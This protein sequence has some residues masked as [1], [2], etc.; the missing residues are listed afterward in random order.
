MVKT[1][2]TILVICI[3]IFSCCEVINAADGESDSENDVPDKVTLNADRVSFNDETG[4]ALAEGRAVMT[5]NDTTIMAERIEY[6]AASQK[7]QAMPLPGEKIILKQE[8]RVLRGDQLNYNLNTK[9][10]ILSGAATKIGIGENNATLYVHGQDI[11]VIP[12]SVA[13]ERGLVRGTPEDYFVRWHNVTFTTCE[14]DHPHYRLES[15][16]ITFI[17]GKRIIARRPRVYLGNTYLFTSPFD[18][19]LRLQRKA[20]GYSFLPYLQ[21]SDRKGS[22]GGMSGALGWDTGSVSLGGSWSRKAKFEYKIDIDQEIND[23]FSINIGVEHTWNDLWREKFYHPYASLIYD[24]NGWNARL[25]WSRN[26][27]ISERKDAITE[28]KGKVTREPEFIIYAPWF[29]SSLYSWMRVF[30]SYG[31]YKESLYMLPQDRS[32]NRYGV[33]FRNYFEYPF[34]QV[35]LFADSRG[36]AWFYDKDKTNMEM[37]RN[38]TGIRYNL[39]A[40]ELGTGY[41]R[42]YVWGRSAMYWDQYFNLERIHQ[43]VRFPVG[44]EVYLG[45]RGSY[46]LKESKIDQVIYSVQWVTDCMIWDLHY[47]DERVFDGDNSLGLT[48]SINAY[49]DSDVSFGQRREVDPFVRP[50]EVP[51]KTK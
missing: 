44:R 3:V 23:K 13:Q 27:Y 25:T 33:G 48:I 40:L 51:T 9:E 18:Y 37:L 28:Y 7:V 46:D 34:G 16:V 19:V 4:N 2:R 24:Y 1:F 29:K 35:T 39:G 36:E 5:F 38:F 41:E 45:V 11:E 49:P 22:G 17:P 43:K 42:Q 8:N 10:G 15:K 12:W 26:E 31:R 14:L 47:K 6:D 20:I 30:A 21:R 32:V 50:R